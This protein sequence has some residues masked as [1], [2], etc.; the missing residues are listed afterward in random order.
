MNDDINHDRLAEARVAIK[1]FGKVLPKQAK[2]AIETMIEVSEA[3]TTRVVML[4][5][6]VAYLQRDASTRKEDWK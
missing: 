6:A 4:E 5:R 3:L 1:L 2:D